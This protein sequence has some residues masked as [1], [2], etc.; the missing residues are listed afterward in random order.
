[1]VW[2]V[3]AFAPTP[4]GPQAP[5]QATAAGFRNLVFND[6]FTTT[7][8]IA[9]SAGATSGFNW[10][11]DSTGI[12]DA[13]ASDFSSEFGPSD[14]YAVN[15]AFVPGVSDGLATAPGASSGVLSITNSHNTFSADLKTTFQS[16]TGSNN[17]GGWQHAYFEA[18]IQFSL[19]VL[20]GGGPSAGWPAFWLWDIRALSPIN[21]NHTAECDIMEYFPAGTAGA[22]GNSISTL[23]NWQNTAFV[24]TGTDD[25]N[26]NFPNNVPAAGNPSAG[27]HKYGCLWQGNGTTGTVSMYL[28]DII[29]TFPTT[30]VN[31]T[32]TAFNLNAAGSPT[33]IWTAQETA[34]MSIILGTGP[35]W[36]INVDWVRVWQ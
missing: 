7:T 20:G 11:W 12:T 19:T 31:P 15:T 3:P 29:Q 33:A 22:G 35:G 32:G 1:M 24:S 27:W 21:G 9:T 18:Y 26:N 4:V 10:Y 34:F 30:T 13:F 2:M 14:Q 28:D 16:Q 8:T 5:P 23:H 36:P 6:D 25:F 17:T